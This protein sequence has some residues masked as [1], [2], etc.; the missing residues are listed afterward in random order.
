MQLEDMKVQCIMWTELNEFMR[1]N[2]LE[3]PN[4]KSFMADS[5]QANWNAVR[6]VYGSSDPKVPMKN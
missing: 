5:T 4:F 3:K 1:K 2:G 6:I